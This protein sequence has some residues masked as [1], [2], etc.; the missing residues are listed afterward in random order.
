MGTEST[1]ALQM[2]AHDFKALK[3]GSVS[4]ACV[5]LKDVVAVS[6]KGARLPCKVQAVTTEKGR[7]YLSVK[8]K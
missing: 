8:H 4:T 2:D 1:W 7:I 3:R 6:P 5:E